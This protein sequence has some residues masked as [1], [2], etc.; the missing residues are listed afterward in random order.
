[1]LPTFTLLPAAFAGVNAAQTVV[2]QAARCTAAMI[3]ILPICRHWVA[4]SRFTFFGGQ[5]VLFV[6]FEGVLEAFH[7]R[8]PQ[9][10]GP[11]HAWSPEQTTNI[12]DNKP[13]SKH[14]QL[15]RSQHLASPPL[16]R[17]DNR[18]RLM[19]SSGY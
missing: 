4:P 10:T 15:T 6:A 1:M 2:E 3:G 11:K 18:S 17:Q 8:L 9:N 19:R 13:A 12:A 14:G 16:R 7:M 5:A